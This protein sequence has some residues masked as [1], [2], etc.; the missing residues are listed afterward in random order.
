MARQLLS[1]GEASNLRQQLSVN[2]IMSQAESCRSTK[3]SKLKRDEHT[4]FYAALHRRSQLQGG[5]M[6]SGQVANLA[7]KEW[8]LMLARHVNDAVAE[9]S[10]QLAQ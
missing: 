8:R 7:R 4:P 9:D 3:S 10:L 5:L 1:F 2:K 6:R